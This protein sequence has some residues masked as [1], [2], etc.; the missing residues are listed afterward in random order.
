MKKNGVINA[1]CSDIRFPAERMSSA[2]K[3]PPRFW[4][5]G[6]ARFPDFA[7]RYLCFSFAREMCLTKWARLYWHSSSG[8]K[9][10]KVE[11]LIYLCS[12]WWI[13]DT[14][15]FRPFRPMLSGFSRT[16]DWCHFSQAILDLT[17]IAPFQFLAAWFES[18][19]QPLAKAYSR[20]EYS[21]SKHFQIQT[22]PYHTINRWPHI[23][24]KI[25][26]FRISLQHK[27]QRCLDI[28]LIIITV[29]EN[30]STDNSSPCREG[31]LLPWGSQGYY[32]SVTQKF[33]ERREKVSIFDENEESLFSEVY[34]NEF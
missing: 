24:Q 31:A 25:Y 3:G 19:M 14:C 34:S 4:N 12:V 23:I 1:G 8:R 5:M 16:T 17:T 27:S 7:A 6:P 22:E 18:F 11:G 30:T 13:A 21:I 9:F 32:Y 20:C 33:C 2:E 28:Y 10:N 26:Q 15:E 29:F